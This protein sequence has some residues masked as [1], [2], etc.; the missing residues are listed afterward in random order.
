MKRKFLIGLE[1]A[2]V[3]TIIIG[4]AKP[5]KVKSQGIGSPGDNVIW[6]MSGATIQNSTATHF[7]PPLPDW[8]IVA[9]C[10]LNGD[11][12]A[13]VMWWNKTTGQ[14]IPWM[15]D[16]NGQIIYP[17]TQTAQID[18]GWHIQGCADVNGDGKADIFLRYE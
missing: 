12:H 3:G 2:I 1:I 7:Y 5:T 13:D 18:P 8:S 16:V 17:V 9:M 6:F 15:L 14:W 10:D 4:V 11:G